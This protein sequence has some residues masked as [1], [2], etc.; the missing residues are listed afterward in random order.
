MKRVVQSGLALALL[1]L[2]SVAA[3]CPVCFSP[4]DDANRIA[5]FVTAVGLTFLPFV[6]VGGIGYWM[7]RRVKAAENASPPAS[8]RSA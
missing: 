2:P 7:W 4:K 1:W 3:A 6:V 8:E 5:Y